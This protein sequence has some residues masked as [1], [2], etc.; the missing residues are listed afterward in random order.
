MIWSSETDLWN[1][2]GSGDVWIAYAWPDDWVQMKAKKLPVVYMH[3]KE[4][5]LSWVGM[6]HAAARARRAST[7]A[8]AYVDAWSSRQVGEV[9]RGQLRATGHA[10]TTAQPA[11]AATCCK[12]LQLDNPK[13]V[14]EPHAH[15]D[16][17]I[18]R[19]ALYAKLWDEVKA[20]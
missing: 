8:H 14:G 20:S 5:P 9:A 15:I 7:L 13:S 1:A 11:V 19:R 6:L 2:F 10:N 18:P 17:D 3:P 16:R 4:R 12:A